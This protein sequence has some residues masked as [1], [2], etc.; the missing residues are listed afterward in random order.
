MSGNGIGYVKM[1]FGIYVVKHKDTERRFPTLSAAKEF[2]YLIDA[3]KALWDCTK[4]P[5]LLISEG[6][7]N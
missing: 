5:E 2:Y 4:M 6:L 1:E 7:Q 3:P